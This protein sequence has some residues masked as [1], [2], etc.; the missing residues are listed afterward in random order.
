[1]AVGHAS[2]PEC[3]SFLPPGHASEPEFL[4]V[5]S[6]TIFLPPAHIKMCIYVYEYTNIRS[7]GEF[8]IG[9]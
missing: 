8:E 2:E 7:D 4:H 6:S 9:N 5:L 1:M 3:L